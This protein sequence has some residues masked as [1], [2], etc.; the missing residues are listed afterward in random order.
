MPE[1]DRLVSLRPFF[2][3][4]GRIGL[5]IDVRGRSF[6]DAAQFLKTLEE[7]KIFTDVAL[8]VEKKVEKRD[9]KDL[10]LAGEVEFTLSSYYNQPQK[11]AE[12]TK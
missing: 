3:E 12:K 1:N 10:T 4:Q 6:A 7:S 8:A 2:D 11:V 9:A 5:N